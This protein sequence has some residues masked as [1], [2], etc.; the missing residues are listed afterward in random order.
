MRFVKW[1]VVLA[2]GSLIGQTVSLTVSPPIQESE[3][4]IA[5]IQLFS[6]PKAEPAA[7]QWTLR[8]VTTKPP[9]VEPGEQAIAAKKRITCSA[10]EKG[11]MTCLVWGPNRNVI[12][13]GIVAELI[14]PGGGFHVHLSQISAA[15]VDGSSLAAQMPSDSGGTR[16]A[17][18][19]L[20]R[21]PVIFAGAILLAIFIAIYLLRRMS[22]ERSISKQAPASGRSGSLH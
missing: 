9:K 18:S 2:P 12:H 19:F 10:P 16:E 1:L 14:M 5:V 6:Q 20:P 17:R 22:A 3:R 11:Q 21:F 13:N 4:A 8:G 7:L 15:S